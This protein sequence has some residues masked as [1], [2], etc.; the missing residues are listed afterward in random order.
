MQPPKS[1]GPDRED[2]VE[3]SAAS[4]LCFVLGFFFVQFVTADT[5]AA[6]Q[7]L[8]SAGLRQK[9]VFASRLTK[10]LEAFYMLDSLQKNTFGR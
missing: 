10:G 3:P 1:S 8:G 9:G 5:T 6:E 7:L 4:K 2:S